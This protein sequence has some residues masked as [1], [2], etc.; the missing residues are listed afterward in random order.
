MVLETRLS[1]EGITE[2][3]KDKLKTL[4]SVESLS[5][6]YNLKYTRKSFSI[7]SVLFPFCAFCEHLNGH[8]SRLWAPTMKLLQFLTMDKGEA[9]Y[10]EIS[11]G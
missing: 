7:S 11:I 4:L 9:T 8:N 2:W 3:R 6:F 10:H 1:R 5:L